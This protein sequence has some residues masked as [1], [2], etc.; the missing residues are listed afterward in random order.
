MAICCRIGSTIPLG[1]P[2]VT[3]LFWQI[4]PM[5]GTC[6]GGACQIRHQPANAAKRVRHRSIVS[7]VKRKFDD[8]LLVNLHVL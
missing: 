6:Q 2:K 1:L 3:I 7:L 4:P 5:K 8:R